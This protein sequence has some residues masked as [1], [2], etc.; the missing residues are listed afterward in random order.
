MNAGR[1]VF[2]GILAALLCASASGQ[3]LFIEDYR[4]PVSSATSWRAN[5]DYHY[6]R[7]DDSESEN[8]GTFFTDYRHFYDSLRFAYS[9]DLR[10]SADKAGRREFYSF[11][12]NEN[13]KAYVVKGNDLF[14]GGEFRRQFGSNTDGV[15]NAAATVGYGRFINV[16]PLAKAVRMEDWLL[17]LDQLTDDLPAETMIALAQTIQREGEFRDRFGET[18]RQR[19]FEAM[20]DVVR[21]SCMM[22]RERL[23]AVALLRMHEVI[24]RERV[25]DR[26]IGWELKA[27]VSANILDMPTND[28]ANGRSAE[29]T[30]RF[31]KPIGWHIQWNERAFAASFLDDDFA[32]GYSVNV[33]S[34]LSYELSDRI[35]LLVSHSFA[36]VRSRIA[37]TD[38]TASGAFETMTSHRL[39]GSFVYF[40]ENALTLNLNGIV[41]STEGKTRQSLTLTLGFRFL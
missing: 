31:A 26:F 21:E 12:S 33:E 37:T 5:L 18:Y 4:V 40:I 11:L 20:E 13:V 22:K 10:M 30:L 8:R 23:D 27:G 41:S 16:T 36:A 2:A 28:A 14:V 39:Q 17:E 25:F 9:A 1:S 35:D 3:N 24:A 38:G 34:D 32:D 15:A 6:K 7:V 29:A 19:W